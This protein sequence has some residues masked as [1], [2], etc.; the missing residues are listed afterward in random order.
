[1]WVCSFITY[2]EKNAEIPFFGFIA[3]LRNILGVY[4]QNNRKLAE[5]PGEIFEY[6]QYKKVKT[7]KNKM[8]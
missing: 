3:P 1:M 4:L 2:A 8:K 6:C 7:L 5:N